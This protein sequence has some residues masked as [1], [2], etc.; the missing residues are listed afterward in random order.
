MKAVLR[1]QQFEDRLVP[2]VSI[3]AAYETYAWVLV[4]AMRQN[5]AAFADKL[6][7]LVNG[8]VDSA[9]GFSK[10]DPVVTDLKRMINPASPPANYAASLALMRGTPGAG[11]LAW[12]DLLES[13][14]A[15]HNLWME[16]NGFA[17]TG[18]TGGRTAIPG[19]SANNDAPTDSYGYGA[20]VYTS[21][22]ENIAWSAG[23]LSASK[24]GMGAY[25]T[26]GLQQ[27]AAFL[28]TV[29]YMLELTSGSLGHLQN[30]L[31][32]DNGS[33]G[34]GL[35]AFNV[36]GMRTDMYE[37]PYETADG[38]PESWLSTH[39]FGMRRPGAGGYVAGV[40]YQD[41]NGNGFYDAG[42][43]VAATV[44]VR[45]GGGAGFSDAT[46]PNGGFSGF[47]GNGTYSVVATAGGVQLG[48]VT[49]FVGNG[50]AWAEIK[51]NGPVTQPPVT[52]PPVTQPPT[53]NALGRPT[54]N[55]SSGS[56]ASLRPD[57]GWTAVRGATGYQVRVDDLS[58]GQL[59]LFNNAGAPGTGWAP[60][61][62]LVS[63]RTYQVRVRA[64]QNNTVGAWSDPRTF[65]VATPTPTGPVNPAPGLRPTFT[66]TGVAGARYEVRVNDLSG[67]ATNVFP[68]AVATGTI[69]QPPADLVSGR[70]YQWQVRAV[71]SLGQGG[72]G[73]LATFAVSRVSITGLPGVVSDRTPTVNWTT[74]AG[75]AGYQV[76]V[77]DLTGGVGGVYNFKQTGT[78]WTPPRD[79]A[80]GHQYRIWVRA[81]NADGRGYWTF[82]DIRVV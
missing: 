2:A 25:G 44:S 42:E 54:V 59:N 27:R 69:W 74:L 21:W 12:D 34:G 16:A 4:N 26:L 77:D 46:P 66:W 23:Y 75:A 20:P 19:F 10:S 43:G 45:D 72:W 80:A 18:T 1:V 76:W 37:S 9:F 81:L 41:K 32:R 49:V 53:Q 65:A 61:S 58:T 29:G 33:A 60:P 6:Q 63:G 13:R 64:V 47:V 36:M 5:P 22:G 40:V 17:H 70:A 7:G 62:D 38:V 24:A 56:M 73:P 35:P 78:T 68:N 50:N 8:T 51:V 67:G 39:R 48:N 15:S 55:L 71:N 52:Q 79:F 57:I 82:Q 11:P 28:D 3:D 31:G 14:A 30:L